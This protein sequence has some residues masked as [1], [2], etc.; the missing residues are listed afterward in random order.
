MNGSS[1][2]L[3]NID[4]VLSGL[5]NEVQSDVS[6]VLHPHELPRTHMHTVFNCFLFTGNFICRWFLQSASNSII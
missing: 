3:E 4:T 2:D 6:T 1:V 5:S